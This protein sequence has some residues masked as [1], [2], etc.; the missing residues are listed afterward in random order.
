VGGFSTIRF[1]EYKNE[2]YAGMG[3]LINTASDNFF[4]FWQRRSRGEK[5]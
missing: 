2:D 4:L 1:S 5:D 3:F